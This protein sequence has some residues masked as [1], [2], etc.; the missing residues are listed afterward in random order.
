MLNQRY[1]E[2]VPPV[3]AFA[4]TVILHLA[5]Q[6]APVV[7]PENRLPPSMRLAEV[8]VQAN[9]TMP[10]KSDYMAAKNQSAAQPIPE[11]IKTTSS[12][13]RSA[14]ERADAIKVN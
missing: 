4:I 10:D 9:L 2:A 6:V 8:N 1:T 14:G 12:L 13:P 7:V 5:L 11:K 3:F